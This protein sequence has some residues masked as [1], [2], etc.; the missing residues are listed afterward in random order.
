MARKLSTL[1]PEAT[2]TTTDKFVFY[3][4]E[5][6][7][8]KIVPLN[9]VIDLIFNNVPSDVLQELARTTLGSPA[10]LISVLN[11]P[12]RKYVEVI[13]IAVQTGGTNKVTI[14]FNNDSAANYSMRFSPNGAADTTIASNTALDLFGADSSDHFYRL[15]LDNIATREKLVLSRSASYATLGAASIP[16]RAEA[17]GKWSNVADQ[18]TRVDVFQAGSGDF[19]AGS[20]VIVLGHD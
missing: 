13:I 12:A 6:N 9:T 19:A 1:T 3:D 15:Q 5:G 11:I 10:D 14:R 2:P 18:I 17:S 7:I 8:D 4:P 16:G 20:E